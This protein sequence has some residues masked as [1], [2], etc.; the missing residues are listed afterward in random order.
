MKRVTT[1]VEHY[2]RADAEDI[3]YVDDTWWIPKI[4]DSCEDGIGHNGVAEKTCE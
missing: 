4:H 2:R 3:T 1:N